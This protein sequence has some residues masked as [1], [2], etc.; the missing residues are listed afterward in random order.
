MFRGKACCRCYFGVADSNSQ[1]AYCERPLEV[2]CSCEGIVKVLRPNGSITSHGQRLTRSS[3]SVL[4]NANCGRLHL[5]YSLFRSE[6]RCPHRCL[7]CEACRLVGY[8]MGHQRSTD[9]PSIDDI[10]PVLARTAPDGCIEEN[11]VDAV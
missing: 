6:T 8:W 7:G 5:G 1:R 4:R 11:S 3:Q 9:R 10:K 2:S